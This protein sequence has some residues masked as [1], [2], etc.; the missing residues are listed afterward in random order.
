MDR[1]ALSRFLTG[2]SQGGAQGMNILRRIEE[3]QRPE[4][5]GSASLAA[6]GRVLPTVPMELSRQMP[7]PRL[8]ANIPLLATGGPSPRP[9]ELSS[10]R[11]RPILRSL[12]QGG[13]D[14]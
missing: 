1:G 2:F 5:P 4:T 8:N 14:V 7:L 3:L 11:L 12:R 13:R 6:S 10:Q 9:A